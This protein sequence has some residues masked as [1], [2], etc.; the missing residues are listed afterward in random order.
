MCF[1]YFENVHCC[2]QS[3]MWVPSPH[4]IEATQ[5]KRT[6]LGLGDGKEKGW[7]GLWLGPDWCQTGCSTSPLLICW[8]LQPVEAFG[9]R[10]GRKRKHPVGGFQRSK[11]GERPTSAWGLGCAEEPVKNTLFYWPQ[12]C[13]VLKPLKNTPLWSPV[14]ESSVST[15]S[16]PSLATFCLHQ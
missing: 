8:N 4:S 1:S 2:V 5:T 13:D 14:D 15:A 12:C 16:D 10:A 6:S 7:K 3:R 9:E 11:G